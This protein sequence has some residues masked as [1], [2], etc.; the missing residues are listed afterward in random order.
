MY[1][2]SSDVESVTETLNGGDH[3][4]EIENDGSD[5]TQPVDDG[6]VLVNEIESV[7]V[8]IVN[9]DLV[10]ENGIGVQTHAY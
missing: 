7:S 4:H 9:A 2:N 5:G 8:V 10:L 1:F 6:C 3:V